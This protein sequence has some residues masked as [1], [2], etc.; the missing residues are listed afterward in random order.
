MNTYT[1]LFN[2]DSEVIVVKAGIST[3]NHSY[4]SVT[5]SMGIKK[6]GRKRDP[7]N[8]EFGV[9][10]WEGGGSIHEEILHHFPDMADIVSLHLSD[11]DGV[12]M[13]AVENGY[14]HYTNGNDYKTYLRLSDEDINRL[15]EMETNLGAN[16]YT[17]TAFIQ[18]M[19]PKWKREADA[20][21]SKYN[22][23]P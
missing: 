22:L 16:K 11:T 10:E 20:V 23:K 4:F 7:L 3:T 19:L 17:F 13:Y 1:K 14:Y 21:I 18:T 8:T 9:F 15:K 12:P 5:G 2:N 6:D